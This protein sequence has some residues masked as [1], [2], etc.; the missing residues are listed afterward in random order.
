LDAIPNDSGAS[1]PNSQLSL[2]NSATLLLRHGGIVLPGPETKL[3]TQVETDRTSAEA[4]VAAAGAEAVDEVDAAEVVM[5]LDQS[6]I[7]RRKLPG[8]ARMQTKHHEPTI[9]GRTRG[10]RRWL[11][12]GSRGSRWSS[13]YSVPEQGKAK[14]RSFG[15]MHACSH[16]MVISSAWYI[17][18]EAAQ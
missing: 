2:A 17:E 3:E 5:L 1:K 7:R 12:L 10:E 13:R 11:E 14:W 8:S 6:T 4:V 18:S 9:T 15:V 16:T